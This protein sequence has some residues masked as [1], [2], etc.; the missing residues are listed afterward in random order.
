MFTSLLCNAS[1]TPISTSTPITC[2]DQSHNLYNV[3][4]RPIG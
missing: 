3:I 1:D 4:T 2:R